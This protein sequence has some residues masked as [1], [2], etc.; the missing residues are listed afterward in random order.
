MSVQRTVSPDSPRYIEKE[1]YEF[2]ESLMRPINTNFRSP[3]A[4]MIHNEIVADQLKR[5]R[6][7]VKKRK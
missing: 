6:S 1:L 4:E 3:H 5:F 7:C 2:I